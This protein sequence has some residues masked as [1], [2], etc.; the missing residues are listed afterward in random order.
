MKK[1]L[2]ALG[3]FLVLAL[4]ALPGSACPCKS[5]S[6]CP[7]AT[8]CCGAAPCCAKPCCPPLNQC[9]PAA[10]CCPA[11]KPCCPAPCVET[12]PCPAAP[13]EPCCEKKPTCYDCCD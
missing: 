3:A 2:I 13:I 5:Q 8:P 9:C 1:Q 6:C 10:P 12:C 4:G 7:M 11:I